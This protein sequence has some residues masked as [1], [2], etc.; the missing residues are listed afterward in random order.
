MIESRY[1]GIWEIKTCYFMDFIK[2]HYRLLV[3]VVILAL[4]ISFQKVSF[5]TSSKNYKDSSELLNT[6]HAQ[7]EIIVKFS[8][9]KA[10]DTAFLQ[11]NNLKSADKIL[12]NHKLKDKAK[13]KAEAV[14]INRL[15]LVRLNT[16]DDLEKILNALNNNPSIEY[17]E[18]NYIVETALTPNDPQFSELWS[19]HNTGQANGTPDADIDAP[20]AWNFVTASNLKVGIIDTGID[21]SHGDL[22]SNIWVNPGEIAGNGIDDDNN[23]FIDDI[24][25]WDFIN[26]DND[27][28]DDHG[29]GTHVAGIVG[30]KGDN[31][32]GITGVN[33]T[34]KMAGLKFLGSDGAGYTSDAVQAIEYANMMGFSITNNSWGGGRYSQVLYDVISVAN[35]SGYLFVA[36][37]GNYGINTDESAFYPA[38]YDLSNVISVAATDR[39]DQLA[40]FSDYGANS[41]DLGA[42]GV[43]IFS[44]AAS[45]T[46]RLCDPTGYKILSGTSMASPH[47]AGAAA[48]VWS[49]NPTLSY[50]EVKNKLLN[51][52]DF[53]QEL[54]NKTLSKGRLNIYNIFDNDSTAPK[55]IV[56]LA[57]SARTHNSIA[58]QWTAVGDDGLEGMASYYDLRYSLSPIDES[59]FNSA[60]QV[61]GEPKPALAGA[62][63]SFEVK[64]L[65]QEMIYYFALKT[66]DNVKNASSISNIVSKTTLPAQTVFFDDMES[67]INGWLTEGDDG[68]GGPAFWHQSQRRNASPNNSWYSCREDTG[69]CD[70]GLVR[71][72]GALISPDIVLTQSRNSEI[73]FSHY[74]D[75]VKYGAGGI[76]HPAPVKIQ[77][78]ADGGATWSTVL[79][80]TL[81]DYLWVDEAVDISQYDGSSIKIKFLFDTVDNIMNNSEGWYVDDVIVR[82]TLY[83]AVTVTKAEYNS[84]KRALNVEAVSTQGGKAVLT[85]EGYGQMNYNSRKDIYNLIVGNVVAKPNSVTVNSSLEG[86]DTAPVSEKSAGGPKK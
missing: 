23:G 32:M 21:Y 42:P 33:W 63:E 72:W 9:G 67:D 77:V 10:P 58:F 43:D 69:S 26:E 7:G 12:K 3:L 49:A 5:S 45:G 13:D 6:P 54:E 82:A 64:N 84:L 19:L 2:K 27:P 78:S 62:L 18:P 50:L 56:D 68:T 47:T 80:R 17:A 81:T 29:H 83:D 60:L 61:R 66:V 35:A 55:A 38:G 40:Y 51:F 36:A 28:F 25:G 73:L 48:L 65:E 70:N 53:L 79:E 30:A 16:N 24:Y 1:I 59:N 14:G 86:T 52:S 11:G 15:Y 20:E 57:V 76:L 46:C 85:V 8:K 39:N 74:L 37:A 34:I 44:T 31:G 22:I 75:P 41:V 71:H 4:I